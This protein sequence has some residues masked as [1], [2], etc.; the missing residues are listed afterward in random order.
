MINVYL[1]NIEQKDSLIDSYF[2]SGNKFY[3][4]Q[5]IDD[6]WIISENEVIQCTNPD[7]MWIK[8]LPVIEYKPKP[9]PIDLT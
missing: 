2:I 1:L 9:S 8:N 4:I 6:N 3:P 7:F 5:D